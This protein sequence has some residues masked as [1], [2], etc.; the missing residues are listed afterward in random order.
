MG[1]LLLYTIQGCPYCS[2]ARNLL[3]T[4][5]IDYEEVDI[6]PDS[7]NWRDKLQKMSGGER[8][9]PQ[10]Y[11]DGKYMGQDDELNDLIES[12]KIYELLK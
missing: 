8:S 1:K 5:T 4:N 10:I 3:D 11:I 12:K 2:T 9:V 6:T 7:S